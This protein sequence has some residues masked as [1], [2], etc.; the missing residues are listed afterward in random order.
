M[1][2]ELLGSQQLCSRA[3]EKILG[4]KSMTA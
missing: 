2:G 3:Y 1:R 4:Q